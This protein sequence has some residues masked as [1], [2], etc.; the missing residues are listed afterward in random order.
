MMWQSLARLRDLP[1]VAWIHPGHDYT[2]LNL[3]F[4]MAL[5][6][7]RPEWPGLFQELCQDGDA[8]HVTLPRSM[9]EQKRL[10]PFLRSDDPDFAGH[11]G[12]AGQSP[13]A[14]FA[15]LR[16]RRDHF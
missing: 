11:L 7:E 3:R 6:P 5:E 4:A 14:V 15:W 10:N 2:L 13:E 9:A 8:G 1:G 16:E 12:L